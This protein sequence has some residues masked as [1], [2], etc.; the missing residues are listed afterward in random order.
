MVEPELEGVDHTLD[1]GR[2]VAR[3]VSERPAGDAAAAG[4]V[5]GKAGAIGEQHARTAAREVDRGRRPGRPGTD[6][7]DVDV[8]HATSMPVATLRNR[9]GVPEWPK[10]AGCK[11]AGSAFRGSNPLPCIR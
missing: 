7:E 11:P 5:P 4:L 10:G 9:A 6:D 2:D 1:D 3:S 8:A